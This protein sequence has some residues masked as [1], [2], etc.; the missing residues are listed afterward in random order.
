MERHVP[1][2]ASVGGLGR[3]GSSVAAEREGHNGR[4]VVDVVEA[5]DV[6]VLHDRAVHLAVGRVD[7]DAE[8][9]GAIAGVD[10][11]DCTNQ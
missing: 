2:E 10:D 5:V 6:V 7:A 4:L 3:Q 9:E 8:R 11:L 1:D